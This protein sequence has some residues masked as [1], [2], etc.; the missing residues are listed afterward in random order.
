MDKSNFT[1]KVLV[2]AIKWILYRD[3]L[4][5]CTEKKKTTE[6]QCKRTTMG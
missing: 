6:K 4:N 3:N 2:R 1:R 5:G